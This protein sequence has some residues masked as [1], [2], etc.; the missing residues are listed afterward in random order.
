MCLS[1]SEGRAEKPHG[2]TLSHC[3]CEG[4]RLP[5]FGQ[6]TASMR[7]EVVGSMSELTYLY[8]EYRIEVSGW[9]LWNQFFVEE[10]LLE[11]SESSEK[12]IRLRHPVREGVVLFVRLI[13]PTAGGESFPVVYRVEKAG[14]EQADG[15]QEIEIMQIRPMPAKVLRD[16]TAEFV[17][18]EA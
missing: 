2:K 16:A 9:D 3:R 5:A 18:S 11:W 8:P 1:V 13:P 12:R 7:G 10:C 6:M 4:C 17:E 15:R 14:P